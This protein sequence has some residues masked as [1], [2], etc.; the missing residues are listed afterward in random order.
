MTLILKQMVLFKLY[1]SECTKKN[2]V[3]T[4]MLTKTPDQHTK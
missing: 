1:I 3:I 4:F 2:N